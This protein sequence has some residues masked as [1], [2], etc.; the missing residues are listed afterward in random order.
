MGEAPLYPG[1]GWIVL[2]QVF[3]LASMY[4]GERFEG[5]SL[6][7]L[8]AMKRA[9]LGQYLLSAFSTVQLRDIYKLAYMPIDQFQ[10]SRNT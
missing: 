10:N 7:A 3:V 1:G 6:P 5:S 2:A 8:A 4:E 9:S